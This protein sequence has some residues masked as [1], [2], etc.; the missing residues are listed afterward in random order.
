MYLNKKEVFMR[1]LSNLS[2]WAKNKLP[3]VIIVLSLLNGGV[4]YR[5][6]TKELKIWFD[7]TFPMEEVSKFKD[8]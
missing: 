7:S 6:D 2:K 4:Y 5:N 1:Y 3:P 8:N